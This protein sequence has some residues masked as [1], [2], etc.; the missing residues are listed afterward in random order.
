[1]ASYW[2]KVNSVIEKADIL[3]LVLDSRMID[4][5]RNMEIEDKV[6]SRDKPLIYV[7]TKC[8]IADRDQLERQRRKLSPSV[9]VSSLEH[10]GTTMLRERILIEAKRSYPEKKELMVGVLGY[11]NVG[12]SSLINALKGR[13]SAPASSRSGFT[14]GV[15]KV[16]ADG[17]IVL[18]DTPGVI[19]YKEKDSAKH[20]MIGARDP[21]QIKEPDL[22]VFELMQAH[23][24]MVEGF[25]SVDEGEPDDVLEAIA[26]K[27]NMLKKGGEPDVERMSR[28]ILADWQSGKMK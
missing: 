8:D 23:P 15:Q 27:K 22:A 5:T 6:K 20:S 28:R 24:G 2:G 12:K 21:F 26:K 16:R 25:Y 3:L 7:L 18:L 19:P 9:F 1:M 10:Y 13:K 11:P 4:Q 17:R 14:K